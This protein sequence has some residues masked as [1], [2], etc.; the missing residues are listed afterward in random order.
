MSDDYSISSTAINDARI[1]TIVL[2]SISLQFPLSV[3]IILIQ[4]YDTLVKGKSFIH[5]VLM[6]AIADMMTALFY[7]FGYPSSGTAACSAQ[8]FGSVFFSRMSWF[9]TDVLIFQLLYVIVF[10]KY[11]LNK[12]YMDAVVF[13]LNIVLSLV[14]FSTGT[15]YGQDDEVSSN[16]VCNFYAGKGDDET[17]VQWTEYAFLYG[18]YF[19]FVIIIVFSTII[20]CYILFFNN[21]KSSNIYINERIKDSWKIVMLY[22]LAM[23]IAW[24]PSQAYFLYI[25]SYQSTHSILAPKN[26]LIIKNYLQALNVLYGPL[27]S[28]I[29]YTKTLDARRAWIHN[30]RGIIY[31]TASI[32]VDDRTTCSSIISM[33][34]VRVSERDQSW[35]N[36]STWVTNLASSLWRRNNRSSKGQ[37]SSSIND[38]LNPMS[39]NNIIVTRIGEDL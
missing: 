13:T 34:D 22:P 27:L 16:L 30:L 29:F 23:M 35:P 37:Q 9:Y 28:I 39:S 6:I 15:G 18:L 12:R 21:N 10:K 7:A 20:V 24:A 8:G 25:L 19:S 2:A 17:E 4:R 14:L 3:V 11:F 1:F 26:G 33:D 32:D 31:V 5:Y 38:A 36:R